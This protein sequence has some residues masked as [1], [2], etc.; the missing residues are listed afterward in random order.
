MLPPL[1]REDSE[2]A[3]S[4]GKGGFRACSLPWQGEDSEHAP[5]PGTG[6]AGVGLGGVGVNNP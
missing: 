4:T 5:S 2:H 3:P 6:R 1:A